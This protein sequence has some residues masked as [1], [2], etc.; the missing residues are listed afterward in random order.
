MFN[1]SKSIVAGLFIGAIHFSL[2]TMTLWALAATLFAD[3]GYVDEKLS[4]RP[5]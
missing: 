1:T 3:P 4:V 5:F 2:V